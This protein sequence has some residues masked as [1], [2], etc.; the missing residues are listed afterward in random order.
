MGVAQPAAKA[1]LR[2]SQLIEVDPRRVL[3]EPCRQLVLRLLHRHS[4]KVVNL[5]T[6]RIVRMTIRRAGTGKIPLFNFQLRNCHVE[7]CST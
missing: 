2:F 3:V 1:P 4:I 7:L 5:F 6:D